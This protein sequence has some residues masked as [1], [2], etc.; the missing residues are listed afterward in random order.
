MPGHQIEEEDEMATFVAPNNNG[1]INYGN[2]QYQYGL[3][4][5]D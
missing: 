3:N 5:N 2:E 1:W 4:G